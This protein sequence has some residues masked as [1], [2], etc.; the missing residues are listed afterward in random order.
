MWT[1]FGKR[2]ALPAPRRSN[3]LVYPRRTNGV[4]TA[5]RRDTRAVFLAAAAAFCMTPDVCDACPS[6]THFVR[7]S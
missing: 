7:A 4:L 6:I 3:A 5:H 2:S 1:T